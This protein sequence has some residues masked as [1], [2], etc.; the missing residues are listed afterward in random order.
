[1]L[2]NGVLAESDVPVPVVG[3]VDATDVAAGYTA[4][5]AVLRN[6]QVE[7]WG[8]NDE[9]ELGNGQS[10]PSPLPAAVSGI[11]DAVSVSTGNA[12]ACA[13]LATHRIMC[14]GYNGDG[15]LGNGRQAST[16]TPVFVS[17]IHTAVAVTTGASHTCALLSTGRVECWGVYIL[18]RKAKAPEF[19]P[20]QRQE[21]STRPLA[22]PA[23][24]HAVAVAAGV[25][26]TCVLTTTGPVECWGFATRTPAPI[27][28]TA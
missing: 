28:G 4:T 6:G 24:K 21:C 1:V 5:C 19:C 10:V 18:G 2:G 16:N 26:Q 15:E 27:R 11:T 8:E 13:V 12:Y 14:W 23:V 7:C 25:G 17:G 20:A 9:G 3:I 22:V